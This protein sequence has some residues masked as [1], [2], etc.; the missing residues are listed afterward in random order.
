MYKS[1]DCTRVLPCLKNCKGPHMLDVPT[2]FVRVNAMIHVSF[3]YISNA[4]QYRN[5]RLNETYILENNT[6]LLEN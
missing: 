6:K 1:Y 5:Y 4:F 2:N 3:Q